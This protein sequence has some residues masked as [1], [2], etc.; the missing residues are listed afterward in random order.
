M[1][2]VNRKLELKELEKLQKLSKN[3][4]FVV[5]L[6]GI[7]RVG[8]TRLILE[9]AKNNGIYFFV[10]KNKTPR[11]LL[12]EYESILKSRGVLGELETLESWDQ[13]IDLI[14]KRTNQLV[15]FD[16]FQNF[17]NIEPSFFGMLQKAVD[18]NEN[19]PGLIVVLGS[20][21]GLIKKTFSDSK[22]PLYGRIKKSMRVTPLTLPSSLKLSKE[23]GLLK[24][25]AVK[26]Y[27]LFGGYPK[28]YVYIEDYDLKGKA[29]EEILNTLLFSRNAPLEDEV[30]VMLSQEF[31]G[32]S[33]VYFSILE[34]IATGDNTISKIASYLGMPAT[35]LTRQIKE[36]K[37]Y[38]EFIEY[39]KPFSGKKGVY[40]IKH[41]LM[42]FWFSSIYKNLS[43]YLSRD[44]KFVNSL[45]N[46]LP[47]YFGRSFEAAATKFIVPKLGLTEA[48]RQWGKMPGAKKGENTYEIDLIGMKDSIAYAFEFKWKKLNFA[49]ASSILNNL[50]TK[51]K[52]VQNLPPNVKL[53]LVAKKINGKRKLQRKGFLVYDITDF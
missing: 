1:K 49:E 53:G 21:L 23:L 22:E 46:N 15:I 17:Y 30:T 4:L 8:K 33:G 35:S 29:M 11:D 36:L 38:F 19:E 2:F 31:G 51:T 41:P 9:F 47:N 28:Y 26:C 5:A 16:E 32:R 52:L 45:K 13:F 3:K 20:T 24:E 10:N 42:A 12:M 27:C 7:R 6:Y 39:E 40:R 50:K 34:A 37:D 18:L 48:R 14:I 44:Q 43:A 25:D